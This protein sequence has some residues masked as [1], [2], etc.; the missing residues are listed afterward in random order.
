[1]IQQ[2]LAFAPIL[3][4]NAGT[5]DAPAFWTAMGF[6]PDARNGRTHRLHCQNGL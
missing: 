3:T 2:G 4:V 5:P 6:E 1:M